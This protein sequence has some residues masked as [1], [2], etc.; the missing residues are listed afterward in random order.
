M[1]FPESRYSVGDGLRWFEET[2]IDYVGTFPPVEWSQL[3][4]GLQFS[5]QFAALR[6]QEWF[7]NTVMRF[8]PPEPEPPDRAPGLMT[9][10]TMQMLWALNRQQ[11]F[12]IAGRKR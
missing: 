10:L 11:L 7:Q 1:A 5:H 4:R 9:R 2:D 6:Q 3:G 12:S 8:L